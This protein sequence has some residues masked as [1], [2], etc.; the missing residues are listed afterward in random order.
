MVSDICHT[1]ARG[2]SDAGEAL[3]E[4]TELGLHALDCSPA[5][6]FRVFK[7][8]V[9][10]NVVAPLEHATAGNTLFLL[11][12]TRGRAEDRK[13]V[14]LKLVMAGGSDGRGSSG[15]CSRRKLAK[16]VD[17]HGVIFCEGDL[18]HHRRGRGR[19]HC[20]LQGGQDEGASL[21][22]GS[23]SDLCLLLG[24]FDRVGE[25]TVGLDDLIDGLGA[26]GTG[27]GRP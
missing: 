11:L 8:G 18:L 14:V 10:D 1:S 16:F 2:R 17:I 19:G 24:L 23:G 22:S 12:A 7:G 3:V 27:D 20:R 25:G 5:G 9:E 4:L 21:L 6:L 13:V 26:S 15:R